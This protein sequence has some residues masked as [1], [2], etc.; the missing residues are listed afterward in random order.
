MC[1]GHI[2]FPGVVHPSTHTAQERFMEEFIVGERVCMCVSEEALCM[3][4]R[5]TECGP[6]RT[7]DLRG[8]PS[9]AARGSSHGRVY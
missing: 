8:G 2:T 4:E 5:E 7:E 3:W 9:W 6:M 1:G